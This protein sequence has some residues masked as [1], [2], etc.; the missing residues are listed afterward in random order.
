VRTTWKGT[1]SFGLVSVPV[2]LV[3][4]QD[5]A[6]LRFRRISRS[7]GAPVR[8]RRWDPVE[9]RELSHSETVRAIDVGDGRVATIEESDLEAL[10]AGRDTPGAPPGA[11]PQ[12]PPE[13]PAPAARP[14]TPQD[15][16]EA[17]AGAGL[18]GPEPEEAEEPEELQERAEATAR[19]APDPR[20]IAVEG[21]VPVDDVPPELF[22]RAYWVAPQPSGRRPYRLLLA[23]LAE[24]GQ[25][26]I[27]RVV[28]REREHL[29]LV[30]AG[31]G[32]M[33]L[34]TLHW[35]EDIRAGERDLIAAGVADMP[36]D[37]RELA[38][39]RQLV[40]LME[41]PFAPEEHRDDARARVLAY[42]ATRAEAPVAPEPAGQEPEASDLMAA[43]K[44]SLAAAGGEA[45]GDARAS[46]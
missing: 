41:R 6:P 25:A 46:G 18:A 30:R 44:A 39:A 13:P 4:A 11:P 9:E 27:G 3:L 24:A 20:T 21:F 15:D 14:P 12:G 22:D 32:L 38:L 2:G 37:E 36:L 45:G 8:H 10:R 40:A 7:T 29:A 26:A 28:L 1:L 43:L 33:V 31:E 42:L 17:A 34:H 5:P 19:P 35:P 16:P 23:A